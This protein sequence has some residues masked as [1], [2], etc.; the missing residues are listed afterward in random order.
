MTDT[1][2]DLGYKIICQYH[3]LISVDDLEAHPENTNKHPRNQLI[4]I[5]NTIELNGWRNPVVVSNLSKKVTKGHGRWLAAKLRGWKLVPVQYQDYETAEHETAD[6][7]ADNLLHD[8][9]VQ[10]KDRLREVLSGHVVNWSLDV[11]ATGLTSEEIEKLLNI[12]EPTSMLPEFPISGRLHEAYDYVL[13][14][15][16]NISDSNFMF[17]HFRMGK[18]TDYRSDL[19]VGQGRMIWFKDFMKLA[20]LGGADADHNPQ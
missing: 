1:H 15:S 6:M 16:D 17:D 8:K 18:V 20:G 12:S 7:L 2:P 11:R 9:S 4:D 13:V 14:V 3:E 5:A 19:R 10:D